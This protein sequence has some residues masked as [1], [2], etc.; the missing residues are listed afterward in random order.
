VLDRQLAGREFITGEHYSIADMAAYP[1][2]VPWQ[3]QQQN[4]DDFPNLK[5]WLNAIAA[6]PATIAAYAKGEPLR[7]RPTVTEEGKKILFGQTAKTS[8]RN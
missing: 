7:N 2:V 3:N 8:Q 6:R 1:W 5:R 4:I